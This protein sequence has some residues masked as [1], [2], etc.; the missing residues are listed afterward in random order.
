MKT[1]TKNRACV[2]KKRNKDR[3]AA[4]A[5]IEREVTR[6]TSRDRLIIYRCDH[7]GHWHVGHVGKRLARKQASESARGR[8]R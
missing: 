4:E 8:R 1:G 6:G 2:G 3:A 7:C 5:Q